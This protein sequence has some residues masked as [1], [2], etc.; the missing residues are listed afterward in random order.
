VVST[1]VVLKVVVV[2]LIGCATVLVV[3]AALILNCYASFLVERLAEMRMKVRSAMVIG[4]VLHVSVREPHDT[5]TS[6]V[7]SLVVCLSNVV[8]RQ[9]VPRHLVLV[10]EEVQRSIHNSR[11]EDVMLTWSCQL[12]L[13]HMTA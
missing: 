13:S 9:L 8:L 3:A 12:G 10:V 4:P 11:I 1:E 2:V 6:F 7:P 5:R